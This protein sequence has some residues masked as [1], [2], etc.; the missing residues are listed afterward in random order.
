[1]RR[2]VRPRLSLCSQ[3]LRAGAPRRS[4]FVHSSFSSFLPSLSTTLRICLLLA[5]SARVHP[6]YFPSPFR[7]LFLA[8]RRICCTHCFARSLILSSRTFLRTA[9]PFSLFFLL[10]LSLSLTV[11]I[12]L[13]PHIVSLPRFFRCPLRWRQRYQSR[14][15]NVRKFPPPPP[16]RHTSAI[17]FSLISFDRFFSLMCRDRV[18]SATS[19]TGCLDHGTHLCYSLFR[20]SATNRNIVK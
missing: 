7:L 12:Y 13:L 20:R 6:R 18:L 10:S 4:R 9:L 5:R 19:R 16:P 15:A 2:L 1:M 17:C 11:R 3:P 8:L 14:P